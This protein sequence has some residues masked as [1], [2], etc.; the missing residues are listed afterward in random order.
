MLKNSL[1]FSLTWELKLDIL[2]AKLEA[3]TAPG[4]GWQ[5]GASRVVGAEASTHV[6]SYTLEK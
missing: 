2:P 4:G 3:G 6:I 1:K 5:V